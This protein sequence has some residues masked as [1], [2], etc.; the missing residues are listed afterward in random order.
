MT[1]A[2]SGPVYTVAGL[3]FRLRH[4]PVEIPAEAESV[5]DGVARIG[6]RDCRVLCLAAPGCDF[7]RISG[8][9]SFAMAREEAA[10]AAE[11]EPGAGE[12]AVQEALLGPVLALALARRGVFVLHASAVV[13]DGGVIGF[14]GESGAGKSTLARLLAAEGAPRAADD[15]LAVTAEG[16]AA[17]PRFPQL[18]LDAEAMAA[19]VALEPSYPLLALYELAPG[20]AVAGEELTA[21]S[22]T[23]LLL[24]HTVAGRL[25]ARDL[26]AEHLA[27]AADLAG[28]V[29]VRRL[30]VPRRLDVGREVLAELQ[31][32]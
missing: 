16:P 7:L 28:R 4:L 18:K 23:T 11:L 8:A 15:L 25:F 22:A 6:T 3:A 30:R 10:I 13:A 21:M 9:G 17:R 26:L 14:L 29:P 27:F 1:P 5:F 12:A 31:P 19:I 20:E 24:K 32:R 2:A